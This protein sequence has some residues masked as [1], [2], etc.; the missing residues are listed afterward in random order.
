[1]ADGRIVKLNLE[2][3]KPGEDLGRLATMPHSQAELQ[4]ATPEQLLDFHASFLSYENDYLGMTVATLSGDARVGCV[5][6]YD[7]QG[8]KLA[9]KGIPALSL[10]EEAENLPGGIVT[11][12]IEYVLEMTH[13]PV[14]TATTCL[15]GRPQHP[16]QARR[17]LFF[18]PYGFTATA[19]HD[20]MSRGEW[21]AAA[22]AFS[23][24]LLP[25]LLLSSI[26]ARH[27]GTDARAL[28]FSR[29]ARRAWIYATIL[30]G[31]AVWLTYR[32]SRPAVDRVTC[33][34]CGRLRR[35]DHDRCHWCSAPWQVPEIQPPTWRVQDQPDTLALTGL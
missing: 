6:A 25:P 8:R 2:T 18:L 19:V 27:V 11:A 12:V 7:A 3:L 16:I 32:L 28:G 17:S 10:E 4:P 14:L 33:P 23:V 21:C 31:L 35:T 29:R 5:V 20:E 34:N 22:T 30:G 13:P 9:A 26:L 24:M 15:L 1:L